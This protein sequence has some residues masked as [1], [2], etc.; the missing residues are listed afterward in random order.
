M[1]KA[2]IPELEPGHKRTTWE[3]IV[4]TTP[5]FLTVVATVLA[6]LSSSEMSSAQYYRSLAAQ[7]QAKVSDQ[8]G[9]FQAKKLR[10][11]QCD[12][13][14]VILRGVSPSMPMDARD[15]RDAMSQLNAG[16]SAARQAEGNKWEDFFKGVIP[17]TPEQ[18]IGDQQMMDAMNAVSSTP[19]ESS[20]EQQAGKL[21]QKQLDDAA[22]IASANAQA[23]TAAVATVTADY[24]KMAAEC[25]ASVRSA[26]TAP[27]SEPSSLQGIG[28]QLRAA[29]A[30]AQLKFNSNR[31][32]RDAYY[33][34][35][36][37]NLLELQVRRQGFTSDRHRIRSREFFYGMLA[38]QAGVT[39]AT[40]SLAVQRKNL[41][42]GLAAS[43]GLAAVTF[44]AYV[45]M[46]V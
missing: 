20:L 1:A 40:F 35:V 21:D 45:Y 15:F 46:F 41:L 36:L 25:E 3:T 33:N 27:A 9:Y 32:Q 38:A 17:Q 5:V 30:V 26:A 44:A 37:A 19:S 8:W 11:E 28:A 23:F 43:A 22:T 6:G 13:T 34:Q 18:P 12:N 31:Y 39:I 42:W 10:A 7:M 4:V 2:L 29:V 16:S 14:I 24:S